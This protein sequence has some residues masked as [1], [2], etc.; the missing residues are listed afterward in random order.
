MQ[1]ELI[2]AI[3]Q[4]RI[5]GLAISR[6]RNWTEKDMWDDLRALIGTRIDA[7]VRVARENAVL[8]L[9]REHPLALTIAKCKLLEGKVAELEATC[10]RLRTALAQK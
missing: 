5:R 10:S 1:V 8:E 6:K 7:A 3:T 2:N 4:D 9:H